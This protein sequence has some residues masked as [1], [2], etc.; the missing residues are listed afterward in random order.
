MEV[1]ASLG[2]GGRKGKL[3]GGGGSPPSHFL[4]LL[5]LLFPPPRSPPAVLTSCLYRQPLQAHF[6]GWR[7]QQ[8]FPL[9]SK[10]FHKEAH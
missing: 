7:P 5:P 1:L 8:T 9:S 10:R 2:E 3:R 6:M 4:H